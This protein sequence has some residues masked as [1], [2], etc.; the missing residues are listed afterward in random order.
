MCFSCNVYDGLRG[1]L[2]LAVSRQFPDIQ[3]KLGLSNF[4]KRVAMFPT[5]LTSVLLIVDAFFFFK[6]YEVKILRLSLTKSPDFFHGSVE[7]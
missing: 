2:L 5:A 4:N 6:K 3:V 1:C 7:M